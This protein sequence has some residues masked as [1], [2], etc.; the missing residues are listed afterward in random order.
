MNKQ[1]EDR[2]NHL[3]QLVHV[4]AILLN[5]LLRGGSGCGGGGSRSSSSGEGGG[6][7]ATD[8]ANILIHF[9][10]CQL[11]AQLPPAK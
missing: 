4:N 9:M 2:R 10:L 6:G 3:L 5:S 8:Q 1:K 11:Q 7:G